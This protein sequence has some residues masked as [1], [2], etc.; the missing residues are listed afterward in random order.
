MIRTSSTEACSFKAFRML[1]SWALS[2]I[3]RAAICGIGCMLSSRRR[4]AT[5]AVS[6]GSEPGKKVTFTSVPGARASPKDSTFVAPAG[7]TS[8][9]QFAPALAICSIVAVIFTFLIFNQELY[10]T[11]SAACQSPCI[12]SHLSEDDM[13]FTSPLGALCKT[14]IFHQCFDH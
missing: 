1:F 7:V 8:I 4:A 5:V 14:A 11:Q 6:A 2:W 10:V 3:E 12:A 9:D 13:G